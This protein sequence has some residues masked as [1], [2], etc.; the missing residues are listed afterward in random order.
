MRETW[1][2]ACILKE[3]LQVTLR[4]VA[5]Y[6]D[7]GADRI[8]LLFDDPNDPAIEILRDMP[9]VEC[10]PCTEDFWKKEVGVRPQARF[11]RRQN[12]GIT[13]IYRRT[14]QDWLLNVDADELLY[15]AKGMD[16]FLAEQPKD[17]DYVR[18]GPVE[19]LLSEGKA[20][21][22]LRG[23][24]DRDA[25]KTVY[26]EEAKYFAR[27][28]GGLVGHPEGKSVIRSGLDVRKLRQHWPAPREGEAFRERLVPAG[29]D[30]MLIH[31]LGEDEVVWKDKIAWRMDS[32]G[33]APAIKEHIQAALETAERDAVL[34]EIYS[35]FFRA[36][37]EKLE[38]LRD[39][40]ALIVIED[41]LEVPARRMF[42]EAMR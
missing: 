39:Q 10:L 1:Q 6:L 25:L 40:G 18:I 2:V 31:L 9:R 37:A 36:D 20:H 38:R 30:T 35:A 22:C 26:G 29:E 32:W 34:A 11:T 14:K 27:F 17:A 41:C 13:Y 33:F 4:F 42:A 7:M 21:L 28:R 12:A 8:T 3:D 19:L 23:Q 24:M 15:I 16:A 5:W